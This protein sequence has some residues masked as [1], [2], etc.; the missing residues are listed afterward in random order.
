MK[1]TDAITTAG[2]EHVVY[3]LLTAYAETLDYY[4]PL[5]SRVPANVKRLP[6]KGASDV[7]ERSRTLYRIIERTAEPQTRALLEEALDVFSAAAKRLTSLQSA[8]RFARSRRIRLV[9]G[10]HVARGA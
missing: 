8:N 6:L 4:D 1:I 2:T 5:R 10:T 7:A 3:F 9:P